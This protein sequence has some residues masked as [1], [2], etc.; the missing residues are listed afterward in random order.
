LGDGLK[1]IKDISFEEF[2]DEIPR[3]HDVVS[4]L[5]YY[6]DP[7]KHLCAGKLSAIEKYVLKYHDFFYTVKKL[8]KKRR[9]EFVKYFSQAAE[10]KKI[11][12]KLVHPHMLLDT[13]NPIILEAKVFGLKWGASPFAAGFH[14]WYGRGFNF[15]NCFAERVRYD[16][17]TTTDYPTLYRIAKMNTPPAKRKNK[18]QKSPN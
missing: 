5:A 1:L 17:Q 4:A 18:K 8:D 12:A 14:S 6:E 13:S 16:K 10:I 15:N 7:N 3:G 2:F 11:S 9:N